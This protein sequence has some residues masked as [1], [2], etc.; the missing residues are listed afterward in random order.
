MCRR[1]YPLRRSRLCHRGRV[2]R[3]HRASSVRRRGWRGCPCRDQRGDRGR[4]GCR[5]RRTAEASSPG[6]DAARRGHRRGGGH[7][8]RWAAHRG[9]QCEQPARRG[10]PHREPAGES[11]ACLG[12]TRTGCC[13]DAGR[14]DG[15]SATPGTARSASGWSCPGFSGGSR[16]TG[17]AVCGRRGGRRRW[18]RGC[19]GGHTRSRRW[20]RHR[21]RRH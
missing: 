17:L 3:C 21:D 13:P 16:H 18:R 12:S 11:A 20:T 6:S 5:S 14:S 4:L 19:G 7:G 10:A 9:G 15:E 8:S 1:G 2:H